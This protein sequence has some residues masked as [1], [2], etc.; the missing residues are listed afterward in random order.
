MNEEPMEA[1]PTEGM[2]VQTGD[3]LERIERAQVDI[4]I[5]TA[6]RYP[7]QMAT[8]KKEMLSLATLDEETAAS[9]FYTLK[10]KGADGIKIIQGPS[11]RLA[12]IAVN[13]F[14]NI[15]AGAQIIGNDGKMITARAVC[16]DLQKNVC[17]GVEVKRRIT[18]KHG[19][20]Y[21]EDMQVVT[22]NAAC[23]IA[24]RNAVFKVIPMALIKPIYEQAKKVAVGD[25]NTLES[26]R[27][28]ALKTFN[29]M[30]VDN[31][32]IFAALGVK[33][34]ED[35]GLAQIEILI[36]MYTAIKDGD[37][38]VDEQFPPAFSQ[39]KNLEKTPSLF[40]PGA[41]QKQKPKEKDEPKQEEEKT[42][43]VQLFEL[44]A[45]SKRTEAQVLNAM[46]GS[47]MVD[48]S[49]P[50]LSTVAEIQPSAINAAIKGWKSIDKAIANS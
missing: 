35:I 1:L 28:A 32:R 29:E 38:T 20:T 49:M 9:C 2:E 15:K 26:R 39:P 18:D 24:L 45:A 3:A 30:G 21:S 33:G 41:G 13:A 8:V 46:R 40:T 42:P 44:M 6:H 7:R 19:R 37:T 17:V 12:E 43:L 16:H 36:G 27:A 14:G 22:G 34:V 5:A 25:A 31:A 47:G 4:Q 48:D 50:D 10:R 11:A 23:S